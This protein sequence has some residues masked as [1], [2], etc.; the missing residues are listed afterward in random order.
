MAEAAA[1]F[2]R[3][4]GSAMR[5]LRRIRQFAFLLMLAA[6]FVPAAASGRTTDTCEGVWCDMEANCEYG[7][8]YYWQS[9]GYACEDEN[10]L[11][12][13]VDACEIGGNPNFSQCY[14]L[15]CPN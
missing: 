10:C 4:G 14:C 8:G 13:T 11:C 5:S 2:S 7:E 3:S 15:P 6:A 9:P 12:E 1:R